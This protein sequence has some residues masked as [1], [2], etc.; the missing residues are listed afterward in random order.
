MTPPRARDGER[1]TA[2]RERR[3]IVAPMTQTPIEKL[4]LALIS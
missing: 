4:Q 1:T 2:G 3:K